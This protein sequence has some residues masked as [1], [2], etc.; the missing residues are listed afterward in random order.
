MQVATGSDQ[1][2]PGFVQVST[3]F[4]PTVTGFE[5]AAAELDWIVQVGSVLQVEFVA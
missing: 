2:A 5:Q 1:S 4:V 3:Q